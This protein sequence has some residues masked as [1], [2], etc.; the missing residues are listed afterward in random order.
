MSE[1]VH[2]YLYSL[3]AAASRDLPDACA[4]YGI[5]ERAMAVRASPVVC[6]A[7]VVDF[8]DDLKDMVVAVP[9][10]QRSDEGAYLV[11][12][13]GDLKESKRG[14]HRKYAVNGYTLT[15]AKALLPV[16]RSPA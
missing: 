8:T 4:R 16:D 1:L 11:E 3:R 9:D 15:D 13:K 2:L 7:Q 5:N 6:G 10:A 12:N 14:Q